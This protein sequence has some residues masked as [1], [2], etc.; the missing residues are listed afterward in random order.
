MDQRSPDVHN[1]ASAGAPTRSI[2]NPMNPVA[3][4][5]AT[6]GLCVCCC[7]GSVRATA[8]TEHPLAPIRVAQTE[9]VSAPPTVAAPAV[10]EPAPIQLAAVEPT[11]MPAP[12]PL[13]VLRQPHAECGVGAGFLNQ[14]DHGICKPGTWDNSFF[15]QAGRDLGSPFTLVGGTAAYALSGLANGDREQVETAGI[16]SLGL[17][18]TSAT[19]QGL[20]LLT[21]RT[22]PDGSDDASFPS[23]HTANTFLVAA[24]LAK[25]YGGATAAVSY[26]AASFVGASRIFGGRHHFTDV[27]AGAV[28]GQL[29]GLLVTSLDK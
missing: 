13:S 3:V 9:P 11:S 1:P 16:M 20:K 22:R 24:V 25:E 29:F 28:I 23:G 4:A 2:L 17:V 12:E 26:G 21:K 5:C 8:A 27:L 10:T 18:G 19:V 6:I 15:E 14:L 7:L